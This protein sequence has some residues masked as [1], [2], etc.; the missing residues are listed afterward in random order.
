[1][2]CKGHT[3]E[4]HTRDIWKKKIQG[5]YK[6]HTRDIRRK[7]IQETNRRVTYGRWIYEG[8]TYVVE[9]LEKVGW[10]V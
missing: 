5:T 10:G 2:T 7:N 6:G 3:E 1:M 9:R 8:H 4:R